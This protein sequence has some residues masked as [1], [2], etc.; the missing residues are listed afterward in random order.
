[1]I[2]IEDLEDPDEDGDTAR[3]YF[4]DLQAKARAA[5]HELTATAS[6]FMLK[7]GAVSRHA[8]DLRTIA[9]LLTQKG[10]ST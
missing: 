2:T 1:M 4:A 7:M 9:V 3:E 6:G 10:R 8:G 5:G